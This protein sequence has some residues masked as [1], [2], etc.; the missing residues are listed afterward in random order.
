MA[1]RWSLRP[2]LAHDGMLDIYFCHQ[3]VAKFNLHNHE[4]TRVQTMSPNA[5]KPCPRSL[6]QG[7]LG[8]TTDS[9]VTL[10]Y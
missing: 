6:Q 5:C 4:L 10:H 8:G 1:T 2:N 3:R 7:G 9:A